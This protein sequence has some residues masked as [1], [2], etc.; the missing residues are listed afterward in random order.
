M[1]IFNLIIKSSLKD[2]FL[3]WSGQLLSKL[4]SSM[5]SFALIIW[6]YK[7]EN[8]V[9]SA[10]LLSVFSYLPYVLVSFLAGLIIDR[11]SKKKVLIFCDSVAALCTLCAFILILTGTLE[12][13]HLYLINF[14]SG[15]MNAFQDPASKVAC[16]KIV[17][18]KYYTKTNGLQSLSDSIISIL[19]PVLATV[20]LSLFGIN[21]ILI[22]N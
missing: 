7:T 20:I 18:E 15:F 1:N 8:T 9:M 11:F 6:V 10:T 3:L 14:V 4:G 13:W 2:F 5:T 21:M 17:P 16:T 22:I 19:T 12:L